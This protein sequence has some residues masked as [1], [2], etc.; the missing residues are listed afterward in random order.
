M[1][2]SLAIQETKVTNPRPE[3]RIYQDT[4][5]RDT[6]LCRKVVCSHT[7]SNPLLKVHRRTD[8]L[9]IIP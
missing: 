9:I 7:E 5:S 8:I 1:N 6:T 4:V 2:L 3:I